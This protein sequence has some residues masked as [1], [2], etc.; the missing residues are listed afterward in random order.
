MPIYEYM[1][2]ACGHE[3]EREQRIT[4]AKI[5]TCPACKAR[6]A[7]RLISQT[8][9]VLKG[10]G[11]YSDLYHKPAGK[12]DKGAAK[13]D[14][15]SDGKSESKPD[16]GAGAGAGAESGAGS[17]DKPDKKSDKSA[18]S[19]KSSAGKGPKAAA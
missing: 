7:E 2:R 9:F 1:C 16:S 18:A 12:D 4:D 10:G 3:W 8:S 5:K 19:G 15:A 13:P 6:K 17:K 14:G 11:W